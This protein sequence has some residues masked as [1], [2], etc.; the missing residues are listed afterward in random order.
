MWKYTHHITL[1]QFKNHGHFHRDC[2]IMTVPKH[3]Y[4][5]PKNINAD[6]FLGQNWTWKSDF[7]RVNNFHSHTEFVQANGLNWEPTKKSQQLISDHAQVQKILGNKVKTK[8]AIWWG[9]TRCYM[10]H[11]MWHN[12]GIRGHVNFCKI[13][14]IEPWFPVS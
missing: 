8:I 6:S 10:W 9:C 4:L 12:I 7:D 2:F 3:V 11:I 13:N 1:F 5:P 14:S